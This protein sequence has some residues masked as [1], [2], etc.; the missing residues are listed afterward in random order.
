MAYFS[1]FFNSINGCP[2]FSKFFTVLE[3]TLFN[4][5]DYWFS[6]DQNRIRDL[7]IDTLS[8]MLSMGNVHPGGRYLVVDGVAGLLVAAV[9]ER[10]GGISSA[11]PTLM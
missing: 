11:Y 4:I 7:R 10:L 8:Q 1:L 2:R 5:S 9:L 3:P 6:K